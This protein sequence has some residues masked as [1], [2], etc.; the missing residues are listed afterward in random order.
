MQRA[1]DPKLLA[2]LERLELRARSAVEGLAGGRHSS[3]RRGSG[4][5]FAEHK[6]YVPGDELRHIDWRLAARSDRHFVRRFEEENSL[7]GWLVLDLSASMQFTSLDWNKAE[8]ATWTAAALARLL[9]MQGDSWGLSLCG[10][11]QVR[12]HLPPR[13]GARHFHDTLQV[14]ESAEVG[15][16]GDPAEALEA[17]VH[18]MDR[19]GLVVW[20]TDNLGDP[21]AAAR[22]AALVR[23]NGH[24]CV[25][26]RVLDPAE[27]DFPFGQS[28]RFEG[29]EAEGHLL[30]EP[31]AI[32]QAYLHEFEAHGATLRRSLRGLGADFQRLPTH[33]P[34]EAGLIT[35]LGR[36]TSRLQRRGQ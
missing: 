33:E 24:D 19:K 20:I 7:T 11:T 27:I 28:T 17:S 21:E 1:S 13:G 29:L 16:E 35:F 5:T 18:A 36:R 15:G 4:T 3:P 23:R 25:V 30:L 12:Q 31:R 14:L 26:L 6:A 10:G 8:Y 32:R 2:R 9:Q 34:L 22:A